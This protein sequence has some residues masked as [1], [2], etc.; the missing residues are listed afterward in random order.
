[1]SIKGLNSQKKISFLVKIFVYLGIFK[2]IV[3]VLSFVFA[4]SHKVQESV[5]EGLSCEA[6]VNTLQIIA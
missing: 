3:C 2:Y 1:M 5:F 4:V 6:Y